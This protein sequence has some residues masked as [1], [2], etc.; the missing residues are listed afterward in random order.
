MG[1][2]MCR[3]TERGLSGNAEIADRQGRAAQGHAAL[4]RSVSLP[5]SGVK[6]LRGLAAFARTQRH[7][8]PQVARAE[9]R[10]AGN[11]VL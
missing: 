10:S 3:A 7:A 11:F 6:A 2:T 8:R 4:P 1:C 5:R 9:C